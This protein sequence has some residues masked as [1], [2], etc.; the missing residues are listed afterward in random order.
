[1]L[2]YTIPADGEYRLMIRDL[3]RHG[4]FRYVYRLN[5]VIPAADFE[6]K[7]AADEFTLTPG[8]PLEVPVTIERQ[9]GF[10]GEVTITAVDLPEGVTATSVTSQKEG[11]SA[12]SVK[13]SLASA[14]GPLSGTLRIVG[15]VAG[16]NPLGRTAEAPIAGFSATIETPWLTVLKPPETKK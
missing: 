12:K 2:E 11:D 10:D 15:T 8:T 9:N 3:H 16:D 1:M 5:G 4:G 7:L 6:L 14:T 13:L